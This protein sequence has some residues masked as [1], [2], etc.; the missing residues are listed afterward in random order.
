MTTYC[1]IATLIC[2][3]GTAINVKRINHC[4]VFWTIGEIMWIIY[5]L[6]QALWSRTILD[7]VGLVMAVWGIYENLYKKKK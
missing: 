3:T 5:D 4:F 2:L 7:A 1:W 6:G